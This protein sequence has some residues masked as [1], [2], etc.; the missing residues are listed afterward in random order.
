MRTLQLLT[1]CGMVLFTTAVG[2]ESD[3][4]K[5]Q[6]TWALMSV[7]IDGQALSMNDLKESRLVIKGE[8]YVFQFRDTRLAIKFKLDTSRAPKAIDLLVVEGTDKGKLYKGIYTLEGDYYK[9]CRPTQPEHE[10][11]IK[12]GTQAESGLMMNVYKRVGK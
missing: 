1:L 9:I 7:E 4:A 12:F 10:R 2:Q 5:L 3:L 6:G 11:P 8:D